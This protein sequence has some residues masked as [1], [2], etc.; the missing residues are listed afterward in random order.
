MRWGLAD[1]LHVAAVG[2]EVGG[3]GR[4]GLNELARELRA[5]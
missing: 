5:E 4:E 1:Y 2:G 3:D